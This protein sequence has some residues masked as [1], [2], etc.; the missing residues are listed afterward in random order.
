MYSN[1]FMTPPVC[2]RRTSQRTLMSLQAACH[3]SGNS[4][5]QR[6]SCGI[7]IRLARR[8]CLGFRRFHPDFPIQLRYQWK[9]LDTSRV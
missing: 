6:D 2:V 1:P 9:S 7:T 3:L 4:T 8:G 5:S